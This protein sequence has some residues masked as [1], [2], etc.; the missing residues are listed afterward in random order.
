MSHTTAIETVP[1]DLLAP[2]QAEQARINRI[3]EEAAQ[4][5]SKDIEAA[6]GLALAA[7]TTGSQVEL[8]KARLVQALKGFMRDIPIGC[9]ATVEDA[10]QSW[11]ELPGE[12]AF[13]LID[14]HA[15]GWGDIGKMMDEWRLARNQA[16]AAS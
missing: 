15:D 5:R 11:G 16:G 14:R 6:L 9:E 8:A 1:D 10:S 12:Q 3:V 2:S 4:A 13:L 7:L